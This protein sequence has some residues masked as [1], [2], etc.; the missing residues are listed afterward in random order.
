MLSLF[1]VPSSHWRK[2]DVLAPD[3][4]DLKEGGKDDDGWRHVEV[5]AVAG[6]PA[7]AGVEKGYRVPDGRL[8][9]VFHRHN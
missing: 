2:G 9:N 8:R 4:E 6:G 5:G 7:A 1:I 3:D